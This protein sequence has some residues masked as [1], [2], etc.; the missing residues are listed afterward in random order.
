MMLKRVESRG[1]LLAVLLLSL[2]ILPASAQQKALAPLPGQSLT[3][4]PD[5]RTL[6][7]GGFGANSLPVSDAFLVSP[8]GSSVSV[9]AMNFARVGHTATVLPDGT[10]FIFGGA[11]AD[12]NLVTTAESYDP[13][14]QQFSVQ[15]DVFAVPRVFHTATLLTDGNLLLA[16]GVLAGGEFPDD[17][18]LW[19]YRTR[20]ALS[21]HALLSVPREGHT[22]TLLSDGTVLISGGTDHFGKSVSIDEIYDPA[23]KRFHFADAGTRGAEANA[24]ASLRIAVSIPV[25]GATDVR[26]ETSIAVRFTRLLDVKTVSTTTLTLVGPDGALVNATVTP[27]EA[28]RLLFVLPSSPL[29]PGTTYVLRIKGAAD[30]NADQLPDSSIGFTTEGAPP[31]S[32]GPDWIP[33]PGWTTGT[34][35]STWQELPALQA[36]PGVT[37][38]AGQA[39]RLDG[40]PLEHVTIEIDGKKVHSDGTGRFLIKGLTAG[41]HVM[42]VEGATANHENAA[43]GSFEVGVTILPNK[44]NILGYAIWMTRLDMQ[45]AMTIPSPTLTETVLTN[46]SMP[47]LELHLPPNTTI[48]DHYGRPVH[49]VSITPVPLDKPPFPLP[50]GVQVPIYFTI[51]PGGAYISVGYTKDG[52]KGA[53]LIYP[54]AFN[55]RPGTP[56][57]FWNYSAD[58]KGW[59]IYGSGHVSPNGVNVIPDPGVVIYEFS[60]AMVGGPGDA[61]GKAP[62]KGGKK[63]AGDPVDLATGQFIYTKTDLSLPD[64]L[65]I[66]LSRT[67]ITNDS[68]SRS[69]GIG[70]TDSYDFFMVGDTSPYT[71]QELIQPDGGRIR[72]DRVSAGT[73]NSTAVYIATTA[74]GEFYGAVMSWRGDPSLP[75]SWTIALKDGTLLSFPDSINQTN[76]LCQAVV[77]I[78]DR[79]GNV[80][81]IDRVPGTCMLSKITSPNGRYITVTGDSSNR[82]TQIADNSGR[83]VSYTYDATGRLA[84]VTDA[85]GGVTSYTYDDQ[86]RMLTIKDPRNIVYLTNQYDSNGRVSQQAQADSGTYLFSWTPT[87]NTNQV[88]FYQSPSQGGGGSTLTLNGCWGGGYNR[89]SPN[90]LEGYMP[91]VAQVN[92]TDPRG[93]VRQVVFGS[94]GYATSDTSAL[95]QPEQQTTTY[96]YYSDNLL[97]SV[98]DA[99]GRVTSFDY[100]TLGNATRI[101]RLSGTSNAV[102]TTFSFGGPFGQLSSVTDPLQHTSSFSYDPGGNLTTATDPLNHSTTFGYNGVGQ[103]TSVTDALNNQVQF[104]YFGGD[105]STVIDPL[106]N[107]STQFTDAVGRV[108]STTDALGN[109]STTQYSPLNLITQVTDAQGNN[110]GFTYDGNGNLLTLTD[111]LNHTTTWTYDNM[112]RVATRKDALQRLETNSYDL[113]G[114]LASTTDRKGLVTSVTYDALN[115]PK[116][117]GYNTVTNG[118]N[119]TYESTTSNTYDGYDRVTQA[120]DSAGGTITRNYDDINRVF[121]ETTAQGSIAYTYDAAWRPASMTVAG[122]P[123]VT[124]SFDNANRLTGISQGTSSVGFGYDNANR[125]S[126]LTLPNG[127]TVTYGYDNDSRLTGITYQFGTNTLGNLTYSY[128][129]RGARTQ[130]GGSFARTNLPGMITSAVYDAANELTGWN[131]I[132]LSYDAN[133]NMLGDGQNTFTWNARNQVAALNGVSLQYDAFGRRIKNA[134]GTSFLFGGANATQE[135]SGS[136]VTAN[137]LTGGVDELFLRTDGSGAVT[138][139]TDALG[140]VIALV[141]SAGVVA[142]TY[143]YDPFGNTTTT[144]AVSANPSQYTGRENEANGLYFYRGRY[145]SAALHRFVSQDP[146]GFSGSGPNLYAYAGNNP[147]TFVDPFGLQSGLAT[148]TTVTVPY[149]AEPSATAVAEA[150]EATEATEATSAVGEGVGLGATFGAEVE[151][152]SMGGPV[153]VLVAVDVGLGAY[154]YNKFRDLCTASEWGWCSRS[155]S[156]A[157]RSCKLHEPE[158]EP[159]PEPFMNRPL[160]PNRPSS[161]RQRKCELQDLDST[162]NECV[163]ECEGGVPHREKAGRGYQCDEYVYIDW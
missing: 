46:P 108:I 41:H 136:T 82:I 20:K 153:G 40:W 45:H 44:T 135:L 6:R 139:L 62:L 55:L 130:V 24:G 65:P 1:W 23:T 15:S 110:T 86:N 27:A 28:G 116:L 59:Y 120:V 80:T 10:V 123:Q 70:A 17:V 7:T 3:L 134:V 32:P 147:V 124:Y 161:G 109:S 21:H 13:A 47:G 103:V 132:A 30:A 63:A 73:D 154:D 22:A 126:S 76:P 142:T 140:N 84:T 94:T 33:G 144:G 98:T 14:S 75:G 52:V 89:Y 54:N 118:G 87:A 50:A 149:P 114:N 90:C 106:G 53:R 91:L 18:Q 36:A 25:A 125:R 38:L 128:D 57:D 64:T 34:G 42:W 67:Y 48:T 78:K 133:G 4:L 35:G 146:L 105:L 148:P 74:P 107:V 93:Y 2:A 157:G 121:T 122:Q 88:H 104:G 127:V 102:T 72:F 39:L 51:Q 37:A 145:Y 151:T 49:Q 8:D 69:F 162:T 43:Y 5:G 119:T 83:T 56:F 99:L 111:A 95:G 129:Q 60:G 101:T 58:D 152:G 141:N 137:M 68:R 12:G 31:D 138:P 97:Q 150:V 77:G 156:L 19:D 81:R 66:V 113:N 100:D 159:E 92:V 117:V 96:T 155:P 79:Y 71:Y 163:Y 85:G 115:R 158:P 9:G 143:T 131:G 16:G 11:G 160:Y 29:Q 112:D 61:P 26:I